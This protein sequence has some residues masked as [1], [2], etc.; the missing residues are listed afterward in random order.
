MLYAACLEMPTE[1]QIPY[2]HALDA[3][4]AGER[5]NTTPESGN[6]VELSDGALM[7]QEANVRTLEKV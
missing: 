1:R 4:Q 2:C 6:L 3:L 5:R 7:Q